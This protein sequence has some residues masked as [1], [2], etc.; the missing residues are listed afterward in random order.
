MKLVYSAVNPLNLNEIRVALSVTPGEPVWHPEKIAKDGT[1]VISLCGGNLL[2]LDE[3]DGKV[4]FIH[5]SVIQHLLS[6]AA[7]KTTTPYH[8]TAEDAENFI[9]ATCITYL[10]LPIFD[11]RIAVTKNLHSL[12]VLGTVLESTRQNLPLFSRVV[13]HIKSREHRRA[14]PSQFDIGHVLSQIQAARIHEDLDPRCFASYAT[15][16][17]IF[18]TRFF[19]DKTQDCKESWRLWWR[20]L[21]G[22]V[23]AVQPPCAS[24]KAQPFTAIL[25][26]VENAHGS[27]FRNILGQCDLLRS[28]MEE[29][30]HALE[31][32]KSIRGKW[33]GEFLT[34]YLESLD[35]IEIPLT[36]E[37]LN[38]F[39]DLGADLGERYST[40]YWSPIEILTQLIC[41]ESLS[42]EDER[43]LIRTII[44]HSAPQGALSDRSVL[45]A[46]RILLHGAKAVA[47]D[48]I[49]A[50]RP[51]LKFEFQQLQKLEMSARS[52]IEKAL[53]GDRWEEVQD[54]AV[55]GQVNTPT[56]S[57][58]SLLW[59]AIM[60]KSDAW[61]YHL[62]RLGADPNLGSFAKTHK[63]RGPS[64]AA[65][66]HPL[67]AALH[68]RR[69]RVCLELLRHGAD[70]GR[71]GDSPM[72]IALETG[73]WI[74]MARLKEVQDGPGRKQ[75][76]GFERDYEQHCTAL[77]TACKML[78]HGSSREPLGFPKPAHEFCPAGD[79]TVELDK[80]ICRLAEDED[81]EY[82]NTQD[83][84]GRT[85]LHY[86]SEAKD[87][88]PQRF[89]ILVNAML[90]R[91]ADPNYMDCHGDT[92]LWL[93]I[94]NSTQ[95]DSV[96]K[97]LLKAGADPNAAR[98]S[99]SF[100]MLAAVIAHKST[101]QDV[102]ALLK[103]LLQA[104][105]DPR[106][107][108][109]PDLP[110]P[111]LILLATARGMEGFIGEF[112]EYT[113]RWNEKRPKGSVS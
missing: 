2:E 20:L 97:V 109:T 46:L 78:A 87:I 66:S 37:R 7:S 93:A 19:D 5:H 22:G 107:P 44:S 82:M 101:H 81:A 104:G 31:V 99:H 29:I 25:W 17:W 9:G 33:L 43:G 55:Q 30:V 92:P 111:S 89:E 32:H 51:D 10:H 65:I 54:L 113:Q 38:L 41:K 24:I 4:R 59:T 15:S 73:N 23:A 27:L 39:V 52:A 94:W 102:T 79:W 98:Q 26:A 96:I 80:T 49:L 110:D 61:V 58:T 56:F 28:Q 75:P 62:L 48:E 63:M 34:H 53:D 84:D 64:L 68:L 85:A 91:G 60:T 69:T 16:H 6:P 45:S 8:F 74:I 47:I 76:F 100:C 67:E 77:A 90:N 72:Q 40:L 105:A 106:D 11:T 70:V 83:A 35:V 86:L 13:Q 14:K 12:E 50:C 88:E 3:E 42:A 1:Q 112:Q 57:G 108:S 36:A 21:D 71:L 95:N 18:H 103:M